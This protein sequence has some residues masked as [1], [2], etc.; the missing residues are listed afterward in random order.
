VIAAA[1]LLRNCDGSMTQSMEEMPSKLVS[2]WL[3]SVKAC[4][5]AR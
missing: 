1:G 3:S 4:A 5:A 2:F